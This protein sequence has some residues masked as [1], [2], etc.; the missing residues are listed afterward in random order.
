[1]TTRF[2]TSLSVRDATLA[3]ILGGKLHPD[4]TRCDGRIAVT[5]FA[6]KGG[7]HTLWRALAPLSMK[8]ISLPKIATQSPRNA[9]AR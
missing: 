9:F 2:V 6:Q 5:R 3:R 1:M 4:Q 8:I 7:S